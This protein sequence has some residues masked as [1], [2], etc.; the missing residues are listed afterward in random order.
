MYATRGKVVTISIVNLQMLL[1]LKNRAIMI[2]IYIYIQI[3][4]LKFSILIT[5]WNIESS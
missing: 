3:K 2:I 4:L 5:K 1:F